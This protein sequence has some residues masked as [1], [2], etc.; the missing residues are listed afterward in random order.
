V[1]DSRKIM[2]VRHG[3]K[4]T[5]SVITFSKKI[6]PGGENNRKREHI[7]LPKPGNSHTDCSRTMQK[8]RNNQ[9]TKYRSK[10]DMKNI[11]TTNGHR[12]S[13]TEEKGGQDAGSGGGGR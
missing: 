3:G 11:A 1:W 2:K 9:K 5:L 12:P 8:R 7:R 6:R 4:K 13:A 10:T